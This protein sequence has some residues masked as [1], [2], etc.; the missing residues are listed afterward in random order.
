VYC[1]KRD[2]GFFKKREK[3]WPHEG[4]SIEKEE[5]NGH[6]K[7]QGKIYIPMPLCFPN[8]GERDS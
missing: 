7:V 4:P 1:H 5:K 8:K 6:M 3:I 2:I